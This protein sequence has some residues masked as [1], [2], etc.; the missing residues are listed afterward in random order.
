MDFLPLLLRRNPDLIRT[1]VSLHQS[2]EI[3]PAT[4]LLDLDAI[5]NNA[6]VIKDSAEA[7]GISLYMMSKQYG[8]NPLV[9]QA[10]KNAGISKAVAVNIWDAETLWR[11]GIEVGHIGHLVQ[12]PKHEIEF[13]LKELHPEV[14]TVFTIEKAKQIS[15]VA[16]ELGMKQDLLL[17]VWKNGDFMPFPGGFN[18]GEVEQAAK[19]IQELPGVNVTGVTTFPCFEFDLLTQSVRTTTNFDTLIEAASR[20]RGIGINVTHI[21]TPPE[22]C[23][24]TMKIGAD[25]GGTHQEPGHGFTGTTHLHGFRDL[26]ELPALAF[27]TEVIQTIGSRAFA[28]TGTL[29]IDRVLGM[30]N[31]ANGPKLAIKVLAGDDPDAIL[32]QQQLTSLPADAWGN[33]YDFAIE[34][35]QY[36]PRVGDSAVYGFR[37]QI[38]AGTR[39]RV[40]VV[41]GLGKRNPKVLGTFDS[42]GN[43]VDEHNRPLPDSEVLDLMREV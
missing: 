23:S 7:A 35:A 29:V 28:A 40:A 42:F 15:K 6:K 31:P 5:K 21:N 25:K 4:F 32:S 17:R 33:T 18:L 1:A 3:K 26:P 38:S 43:L 36:R 19:T 12:V 27:V 34:S 16:S 30:M 10:I 14:F 8:R 24:A 9:C 37:P 11:Y 2:G 22:N 13:V 41:A 39:V 20:L